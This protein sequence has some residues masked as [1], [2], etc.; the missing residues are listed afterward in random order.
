VTEFDIDLGG[1]ISIV[2]RSESRQ[3]Q[4]L[5]LKKDQSVLVGWDI[6]DCNLLEE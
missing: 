4:R 6:E 1:N 2:C 5:G 3:A